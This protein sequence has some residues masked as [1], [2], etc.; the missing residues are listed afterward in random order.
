MPST[1]RFGLSS[2]LAAKPDIAL[3]DECIE[4]KVTLILL[5]EAEMISL[6]PKKRTLN[7]HQGIRV[8]TEF[9]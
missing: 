3:K 7:L 1:A 5:Y 6:F 8:L 9:L 2:L 4:V